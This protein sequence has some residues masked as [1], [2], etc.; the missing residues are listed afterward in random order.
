[1]AP[2]GACGVS[3]GVLCERRPK[4][5][6]CH[7]AGCRRTLATP[8]PSHPTKKPAKTS[9]SQGRALGQAL[10]GCASCLVHRRLARARIKSHLAKI[11]QR[12]WKRRSAANDNKTTFSSLGCWC[13]T[14]TSPPAA[15]WPPVCMCCKSVVWYRGPFSL[16]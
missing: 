9:R 16:V 4:L 14:S 7:D 6:C 8:S 1:M 10:S 11:I 2:A 15:F 5:R 12:S 3:W 13:F